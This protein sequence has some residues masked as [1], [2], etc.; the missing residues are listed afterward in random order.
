MQ[1]ERDTI[2][3]QLR[4]LEAQA[5]ANIETLNTGASI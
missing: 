1:P 5:R 3:T 4:T 2:T